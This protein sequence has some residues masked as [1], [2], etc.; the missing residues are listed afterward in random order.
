MFQEGKLDTLIIS[1][2]RVYKTRYASEFM[3]D[4]YV[5]QGVPRERVFEFRQDAY[6]TIEEAR[7]LIRQFRLQNLD[8]VVIVTTSFHT[9]R[10]R[11]IFRKLAGGYP[12][13]MV[14][15]AEYN[16]YDPNA[17]WSNR[18]SLKLWF[19]E[20]TK[21]FFTV[22]ELAKSGPESDKAQYQGLTPDTSSSASAEEPDAPDEAPAADS[23]HTAADSATA[24]ATGGTGD[25]LTEISGDSAKGAA[26]AHVGK[27]E[28]RTA[29]D[30]A[31]STKADSI[32]NRK[33]SIKA[34][35]DSANSANSVKAKAAEDK[36]PAKE[37]EAKKTLP[38]AVKKPA[39]TSAKPDSK[40]D[41]KDG[42]K[43]SSTKDAAKAS[44][45]ASDRKQDKTRPK[46]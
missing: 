36:A 33:D 32:Q 27:Q 1:A 43:T 2:C 15:A 25:A 30:S 34:H 37:P 10:T 39:T 22:F 26:G 38:K 12:V 6:S 24:G 17:F 11:R 7:L 21:T 9:A 31:V 5:Q 45:K 46:K 8:T 16:V 4:Y 13:V 3:V 41:A 40:S 14:A 29:L 44:D 28:A 35:K 23:L 42:K 18:E 20:W 19:D